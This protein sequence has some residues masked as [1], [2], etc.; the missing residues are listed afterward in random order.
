M[1]VRTYLPL[2][3]VPRRPSQD[4]L[5]VL[6]WLTGTYVHTYPACHCGLRRR[7]VHTLR[8]V[9]GCSYIALAQAFHYH[10]GKLSL[11]GTC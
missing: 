4:W 7:T 11:L 3:Y 5:Y 2:R 8:Y 9:T 1:C 10:T 6:P